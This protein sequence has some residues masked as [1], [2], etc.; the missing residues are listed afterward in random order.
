VRTHQTNGVGLLLIYYTGH[1]RNTSPA[2]TG[3]FHDHD[4]Y[5][6]RLREFAQQAD[7]RAIDNDI[8]K[9]ATAIPTGGLENPANQAKPAPAQPPAKMSP[10]NINI[11]RYMARGDWQGAILAGAL[12]MAPQ[13][14][15]Y[16]TPDQW[17]VL[18]YAINTY[19]AVNF[20][21]GLSAFAARIGVPFLSLAGW[22]S[23]LNSNEKDELERR[24]Q[25]GP[26]LSKN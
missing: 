14:K 22:S 13:L 17:R 26:T 15:P 6:M 7:V 8:D 4:K 20:W 25:M 10:I 16:L 2:E 12:T 1:A 11:L 3:L 18:N 21:T 23:K 9:A 5:L 19:G 24:R